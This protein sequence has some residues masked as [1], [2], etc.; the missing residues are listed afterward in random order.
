MKK[1]LLVIT[2]IM[3]F[4]ETPYSFGLNSIMSAILHA[5]HNVDLLVIK[6]QND[7]ALFSEKLKTFAPDIVG[8]SAVSSQFGFVK[9]LSTIVKKFNP[10]ITTV[11]GGVHPTLYPDDLLTAEHI[12]GFFRGESEISVVAFLNAPNLEATKKINNYCY[13]SENKLI[14][15]PL[16]SLIKNLEV[17]PYPNKGDGFQE[18]ISTS[19]FAP[20]FFSRGCPYNC[21]YC[22]NHALAKTYGMQTNTPRYRNAM[23][24]IEE[25]KDAQKKFAFSKIWFLDDT[26]GLDKKWRNEFLSLY[27]KEIN[28]PFICLLRANIASEE[29][30]KQLKD[31]RCARIIFGVESGSERIRNEIMKRNLSTDVIIKAF[32]LC[33]KYKIETCAL[34]IIGCPDETL[35]EIQMT[36]KLNRKIKPSASGINIFY[37]YKGTVLGDQAFSSNL[38][39]EP[40]YLN[41]S[42]ERRGTVLRFSEEHEKKLIKIYQNWDRQV[43]PYD[44][45]RS[46]IRVVSKNKFPFSVLKKIRKKLLKIF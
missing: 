15:N 1:V 7:Y 12:D 28:L 5:G 32:D 44:I 18:F 46:I 16:E 38:V 39:D 19:G 11:C 25:I 10:L 27:S 35:E 3:G 24:C 42:N 8:F 9:D 30:I 45:K 41:F 23:S 13:I 36:I 40:R 14:I 22:S 37:P 43:Y 29:Y 4:H 26:F 20:F 21:S 33:R 34:N 17:L 6:T 31:A 2:N